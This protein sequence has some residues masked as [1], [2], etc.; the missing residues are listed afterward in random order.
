MTYP[1]NLKTAMTPFPF[2]VDMNTTL[3]QAG[4]LMAEHSVHHLPVTEDHKVVGVLTDRD[5]ETAAQRSAG[6]PLDL[7]VG[8]VCVADPYVVDLEEPIDTVLLEMADRHIDAA[9]VMRNGRLAGVFTWTDACRAFGDYM[10]AAFPRPDG[11]DA[12]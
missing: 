3:G 1:P 2:S 6:H 4:K 12:A 11:G 5:L 7:P 8:D 9:I 10:R